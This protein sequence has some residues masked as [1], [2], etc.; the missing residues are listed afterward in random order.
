MLRE[1]KKNVFER[2]GVVP[3]RHDVNFVRHLAKV[4]NPKHEK[5]TLS[6][7]CE[8][9]TPPVVAYRHPL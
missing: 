9:S 6:C 1:P 4:K 8:Q 3:C 7:H 5:S 2:L